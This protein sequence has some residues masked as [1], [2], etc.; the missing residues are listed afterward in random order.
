MRR[1][2]ISAT[3]FI[4]GG[5]RWGTPSGGRAPVSKAIQDRFDIRRYGNLMNDTDGMPVGRWN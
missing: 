2:R 3:P 1:T 5:D 4:P